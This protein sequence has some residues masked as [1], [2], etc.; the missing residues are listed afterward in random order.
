MIVPVMI[1]VVVMIVIVDML[2]YDNPIVFMILVFARAEDERNSQDRQP[3]QQTDSASSV[4]HN[5]GN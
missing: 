4:F 3:Q 5:H 1:V 2:R